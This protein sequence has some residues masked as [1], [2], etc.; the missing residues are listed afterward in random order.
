MN[1]LL[2]DEKCLLQD[3][4]DFE[5]ILLIIVDQF[6]PTRQQS[7]LRKR[8]KEFARYATRDE[9]LGFFLKFL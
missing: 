2:M 7:P 5:V 3:F 4:I 1:T 8:H 6:Y 9:Y